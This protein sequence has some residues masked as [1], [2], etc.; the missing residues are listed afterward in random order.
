MGRHSFAKFKNTYLVKK[1]FN[2]QTAQRVVRPTNIPVLREEESGREHVGLGRTSRTSRANPSRVGERLNLCPSDRWMYEGGRANGGEGRGRRLPIAPRRRVGGL[3]GVAGGGGT[4][5]VRSD[6]C[7]Y[8]PSIT[9]LN[10]CRY[11]IIRS[12]QSTKAVTF[13]L[14]SPFYVY[15][16]LTF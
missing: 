5:P 16:P 7:P 8:T 9:R 11:S 10:Y 1:G 2:S 3:P 14:P 12:S 6:T 13:P 4:V 15:V